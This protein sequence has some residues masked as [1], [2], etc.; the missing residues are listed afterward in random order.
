MKL[1]KKILACVIA[2]ALTACLGVVAFAADVP[3]VIL[4]GKYDDSTRT[5]SVTMSLDKAKD[6]TTATLF[7]GF[8]EDEVEYVDVAKGTIEGALPEAGL[9][10]DG[11]TLSGAAMATDVF[12]QDT[13]T[14]ATYT[15]KVKDGVKKVTLTV[16]ED[17]VV[18]DEI[19]VANAGAT[20]TFDTVAAPT[21]EP[22]STEAPTKAATTAASTAATTEKKTDK[23]A[24]IKKTGDAGIAVIAGVSALA[25]VAFVVT[26][27]K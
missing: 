13:I 9:A 1:A 26:K 11:K 2:L 7:V 16:S 14:I 27:K 24:T 4:D 12:T 25:A 18:D 6:H 17:S 21:T 10:T 22:A 8:N 5:L 19:K 23:P 3:S 20:F 15:L